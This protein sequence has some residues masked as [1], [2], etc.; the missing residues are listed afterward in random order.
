MS[1]VKRKFFG[2]AKTR[3]KGE[4]LNAEIGEY[5]ELVKKS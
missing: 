2:F 3:R 4:P 5:W 1:S